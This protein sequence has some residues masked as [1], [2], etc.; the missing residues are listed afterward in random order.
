VG[1]VAMIRPS[2]GTKCML[3]ERGV[4]IQ[5]YG[6]ELAEKKRTVGVGVRGRQI[7]PRD[8]RSWRTQVPG[9]ADSI[10]LGDEHVLSLVFQGC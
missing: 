3:Q 4:S 8:R 10:G 9:D 5:R 6:R 7:G 2:R 1:L